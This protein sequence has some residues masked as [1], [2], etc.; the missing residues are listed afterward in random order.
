MAQGNP[1]GRLTSWIAVGIVVLGFL[2]GGFGLVL[3]PEWW[4]FWTGAAIAV[5]GAAFGA[6]TGIMNDVH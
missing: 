3:G 5:A 1:R 4:M 6:A 2:V